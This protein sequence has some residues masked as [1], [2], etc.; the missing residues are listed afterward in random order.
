MPLQEWSGRLGRAWDGGNHREFQALSP[1][2]F[3]WGRNVAVFANL[4]LSNECSVWFWLGPQGPSPLQWHSWPEP[5]PTLSEK[6]PSVLLS[7]CGPRCGGI[8]SQ[9]SVRTTKKR[10]SAALEVS[11][12]CLQVSTC[13]TWSAEGSNPVG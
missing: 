6:D 12:H 3:F 7:T 1:K 5:S 10:G 9:T 13:C 8:T 11:G 2:A 4:F